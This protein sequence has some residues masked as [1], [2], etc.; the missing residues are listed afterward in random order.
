MIYYN[1]MIIDDL[2]SQTA[3]DALALRTRIL[4]VGEL[5]QWHATGGWSVRNDKIAFIEFSEL[6]TEVISL[7]NPD[8]VLSPTICRS[9]DCLDLAALLQNIGFRGKYR[10]VAR[11]LPNLEIVRRE[12]RALCPAINFDFI[13]AGAYPMGRMN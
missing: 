9:F 4:A 10:A 13:E 6:R 2:D 3:G 5:R 11:E 8:Y 7:L 12:V 1:D